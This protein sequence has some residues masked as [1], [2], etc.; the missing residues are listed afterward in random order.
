MRIVKLKV[1]IVLLSLICLYSTWKSIVGVIN[2]YQLSYPQTMNNLDEVKFWN[3]KVMLVEFY[4]AQYGYLGY[5][6]LS[7]PIGGE[8]FSLRLTEEGYIWITTQ[9]GESSKFFPGIDVYEN[10]EGIR[11]YSE[12]EK[13]ILWVK[14]C[15]LDNFLKSSLYEKIGLAS[16]PNTEKNTNY[17]YFVERIEPKRER[18]RIYGWFIVTGIIYVFLG[19]YILRYREE[20]RATVFWERERRR[21]EER[22]RNIVLDKERWQK[23]REKRRQEAYI[24]W[25]GENESNK[26]DENDTG[27]T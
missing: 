9:G 17:D 14:V 24:K 25:E 18:S 7:N 5:G 12:T 2:L 22:E 15:K 4:Y 21:E 1:V 27:N 19:V 26:E 16:M 6:T 20:K 11:E 23:E 10:V 8:F 3:G 13:Q